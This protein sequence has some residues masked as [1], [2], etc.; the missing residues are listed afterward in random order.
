MAA[1]RRLAAIMFTDIVGY[2]ALM[3]R[4]EESGRRAR[5][6]HR[7]LVRPLIDAY[8]GESIEARGDESLSLFPSALDAVNCALALQEK[9]EGDPEKL[10][11]HIGIHQSDIELRQGEVIGDG[12]NIASRICSHSDGNAP[13]ISDEV[14]HAVQNQS[15]LSFESLGEHEFKNVPRPVPLFRVTGAAESPRPLSLPQ[16]LGIRSPARWLTAAVVVLGLIGVGVGLRYQLTEPPPIRS[17]AVLPLENL[18]GDPEQEY[19]ADGMTEAVISEFARIG[20]LRV[21]SRTTVMRYKHS[22]KSLPEIARELNVDAVIEGTVFREGPRVRI[23]TQLID[24]R[25]D[26]HIWAK[27]FDRELSGVLALQSDVARAVAAQIQLKLSPAEM[28]ALAN[29][30]PV[31]PRAHD[32]YLRGRYQLS[33]YTGP[34]GLGNA[35]NS[36]ERAIELQRDYAPAYVGLSRAHARTARAEGGS[37]PNRE[38]MPKAR[39]AALAALKHDDLLGDAHAA[40]GW[41]LTW[42]DW[43]WEQA[44]REVRLALDLSPGD[45]FVLEANAAYHSIMGNHDRAIDYAER[46]LARDPLELYR[47]QRLADTLLFARRYDRALAESRKI[48]ELNPDSYLAYGFRAQVPLLKAGRFDEYVRTLN[49]AH[50]LLPS[51][52]AFA[53]ATRAQLSYEESGIEGYHQFW[54]EFYVR[55]AN[56]GAVNQP[57]FVAVAAARAGKTDAA[58]DWLERAYEERSHWISVLAVTPE[59]DDIRGA[60]RFQD[61]LRRIGFPED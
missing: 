37:V 35:I 15:N 13:F 3:A 34:E 30:R 5:E 42:H 47:R 14:Q 40:L 17:I 21:I 45:P 44:E 9:L 1:E 12:V 53:A 22:E 60:R 41:V 28:A 51:P 26:T 2:T 38:A 49:R 27:R 46:S 50:E 11:L 36:F 23:G 18:S 8:H 54:Y 25:S 6:R 19:F 32:A 7:A 57:F 59:F 56:R 10:R 61:L 24:A 4:D 33:N 52:D 43:K 48:A 55:A 58:L 16:R 31:D 29:A 20:S 39:Q